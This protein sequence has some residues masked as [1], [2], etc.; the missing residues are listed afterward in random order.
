M[1][2]LRFPVDQA[3]G[4]L[5]WL[6]SE[7]QNPV[8]A[9][10][11]VIVPGGVEVTLDVRD[12]RIGSA[13]RRWR[14]RR[15]WVEM[16]GARVPGAEGYSV[17]GSDQPVHLGFLR[18]LPG[19]SINDYLHLSWPLIPESFAAI[20]HLAPGLRRLYLAQTGL[21]D[22][23][24]RLVAQLHGLTYLQTWGNQFTDDGVQQLAVLTELDHL[25]LEEETLS[26][27]AFGFARRLPKLARLGLQDVPLTDNELAE[28]RNQFPGVDVG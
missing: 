10:G 27:A 26:I 19:D 24:L 17:E 18:E 16:D 14:E 22:D 8:L 2:Q 20:T 1:P 23:A 3:V 5:E 11:E 12:R 9:Q 15:S 6:G 21:G 7:A 4:T 13:L 25:Y 28:L